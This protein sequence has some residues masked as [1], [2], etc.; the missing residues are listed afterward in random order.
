MISFENNNIPI[1]IKSKI[2][3]PIV[4]SSECKKIISC[5]PKWGMVNKIEIQNIIN[6][7]KNNIDKIIYIF[8]ISDSCDQFTIPENI[9]LYRTS[10]YKSKQ[11]K[12]EYLLPYIW[13]GNTKSIPTLEKDKF[14][15]VG[16]CGQNSDFRIKTLKLFIENK[17]IKTKFII[18]EKFWGGKPHDTELIKDFEDNMLNS[19]FNICNR[20]NGNF[21]MRF[22]Q[23]LSFGRIPVLLN[24][25]M[26]LPF[27]EEIK[28]NDIIIL[29]D[30]EEELV[31]KVLSYWNNRNIL[32]MQIKCKEIYD[33]YFSNTN[34]LD[35]VLS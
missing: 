25:D 16:F 6:S 18:R 10:L 8:L 33:K 20:G 32:K 34:F 28:W 24:T 4:P 15:I 23:T 1:Y 22:Y 26:K 2:S 35:K 12:N 5:K 9:R 11:T 13:E 29:G 3:L 19:H 14:P 7:Y 30:T 27:E 17:Y 21:S 31:T